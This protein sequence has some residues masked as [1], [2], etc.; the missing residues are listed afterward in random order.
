MTFPGDLPF[1]TE[2]LMFG[3][4][5][6]LGI[7]LLVVAAFAADGDK[8]RFLRRVDQI[9]RGRGSSGSEPGQVLNAKRRTQDSDIALFDRLIKNALPRREELRARLARAGLKI[10]LAKYLMYSLICGVVVFL[11]FAV[12][13][14]MPIV[15][16][17]FIGLF[18][19]VGLPH[20]WVNF[21]GN[22]RQKKFIALFPE[23]I[24][25]MVRGLKSGLPISE[26]IKNAGEEIAD[27]VGLELR[28][29]T[30]AVR[31][32]RKLEDELW[33]TSARLDL[34]EFKFFTVSLAIQTETGG[35]LAETLENL[36]TVLRGRRQLKMKI[37]ALSS[38]AKCSA[39]II[40]SLPFVMALL[41]YLV[42]ADYIMDL[43]IDPRGQF[44]IGLGL[45]SFSIGTFVMYRMC[46]FEI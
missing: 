15:A 44:L 23:A 40:G 11:L 31:L 37:K 3:G 8:K 18:G 46:K 1:G 10:S 35:N 27:P 22:R 7:L 38:E 12:T 41:I 13:G 42:N 2:T 33:A 45:T 39:Y 24:D 30:D 28:R 34:Q 5:V 9:C 43:F 29:V 19:A 4:L 25:L 26:S 16:A 32:G 36:S 6:L 14:F 20:L 21:L 17:A